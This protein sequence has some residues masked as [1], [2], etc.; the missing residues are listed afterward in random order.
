MKHWS[1]LPPEEITSLLKLCLNG[2]FF[3]FRGHY[4]EQTEG[5]I[6][7]QGVATRGDLVLQTQFRS[8]WLG[9]PQRALRPLQGRKWWRKNV[10]NSNI[11]S[12]NGAH[13]REPGL[14][15]FFPE[16][17]PECL[18]GFSGASQNQA[19]GAFCGYQGFRIL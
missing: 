4:Y 6:S 12:T 9:P 17:P 8:Q 15:P 7:L 11:L 5:P 2:A 18:S 13:T 16:S 14:T 3:T 1:T 10:I 19:T